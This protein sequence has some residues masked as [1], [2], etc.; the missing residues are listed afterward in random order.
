MAI[1]V[2]LADDHRILREGLKAILDMS[3]DIEVVDEASNGK[4][5]LAKAVQHRP[6][7]VLMD[8]N[9]AEMGGI[10][11]TRCIVKSVP[12]SKILI[13]SMLMDG[14]CVA[15]CLRAGARGYLLKDCASDELLHAIRALMNGEP[16]L[17]AKITELMIRDYTRNS[18]A[19]RRDLGS[20][21]SSREQEV[22]QHIADGRN[23]KEIAF[24]LGVSVKTVEVQRLNIMKKLNLFSIAELTKYALREGLTSLV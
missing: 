19:D 15:D 21:L 4:D 16:F 17:C 14:R 7:I 24:T 11:A 5:A 2:L 20:V 18:S 8:L 1:K 3:A 9:M 10:E 23:T 13:L 6:D 12:E 22:L